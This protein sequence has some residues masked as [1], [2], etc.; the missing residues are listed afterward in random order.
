MTDHYR[1]IDPRDWRVRVVALAAVGLLL[2]LLWA[3]VLAVRDHVATLKA[4]A[5]TDPG[6]AA[7]RA[8]FFLRRMIALLAAGNVVVAAYLSWVGARVVASGKL[9]PPGSWIVKGRRIY[10]GRLARRIGQSFVVLAVVIVAASAGMVW[11]GWRLTA[12]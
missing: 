8:G 11:L 9:P 3:L 4:V 5:A 6:D 2:A 12:G 7:R 10:E 1:E